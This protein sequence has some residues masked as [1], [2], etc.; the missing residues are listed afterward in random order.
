MKKII[1]ILFFIL[2]TSP[3]LAHDPWTTQDTILQTVTIGT[4]AI[5]AWQTYTF[6]YTGDYRKQGYYETNPI[7]GKYPSKQRF[8]AYQGS[9]MI[10]HTTISYILPKPYRTFWQ[11]IW[12]GIE[13]DYIYHNYSCGV[14][15]KF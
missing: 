4:I 11:F 13:S 12:I 1:F 14:R 7:L 2:I 8:F 3:L 5:D 10:L 15:I 9:C 6:L